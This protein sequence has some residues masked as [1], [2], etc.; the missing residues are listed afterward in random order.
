M[1]EFLKRFLW[2][3]PGWVVVDDQSASY[4]HIYAIPANLVES[5]DIELTPLARS[6]V[7]RRWAR[8]INASQDLWPADV[9]RA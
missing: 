2:G 6:K 3:T 4:D 9:P 1:L 8:K 5:D 7:A